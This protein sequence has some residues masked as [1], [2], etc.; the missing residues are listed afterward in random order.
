MWSSV[1]LTYFSFN[2]IGASLL[3]RD[4]GIHVHVCTGAQVAP[5]D[6]V[7]DQPH[8]KEIAATHRKSPAQVRLYLHIFIFSYQLVG[9]RE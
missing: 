6:A 4:H 1:S 3:N 2:L 8:I 5:G 7:I 9:T